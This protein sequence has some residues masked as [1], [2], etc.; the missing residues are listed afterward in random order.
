VGEPGREGAH[1][2]EAF[3]LAH[4]V[5]EPP[6]LRRRLVDALLEFALALVATVRVAPTLRHVRADHEQAGF[7]GERVVRNGALEIDARS[8]RRLHGNDDGFLR[9]AASAMKSPPITRRYCTAAGA[10]QT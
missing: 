9:S 5:D 3:L 2:R 4:P 10:V 6:E 1:R 7:A 8:V